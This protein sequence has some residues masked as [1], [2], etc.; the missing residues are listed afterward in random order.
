MSEILGSHGGDSEC[1]VFWD[2]KSFSLVD[3]YQ[4]TYCQ[5]PEDGRSRFVLNFV[6]GLPDKI[7]EEI[8]LP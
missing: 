3:P 1:N 4:L 8:N 6:Y 7:P 2:L 5:N